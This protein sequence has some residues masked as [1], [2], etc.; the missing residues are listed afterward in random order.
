M[1]RS[2]TTTSPLAS[3]LL[4][5]GGL[6]L[7]VGIALGVQ[8]HSIPDPEYA[9]LPAVTCGTT[10][11]SSSDGPAK[12]LFAAQCAGTAPLRPLAWAL[13]IAGALA[14]IGGIAAVAARKTATNSD[15]RQA[16][17]D[18]RVREQAE[19]DAS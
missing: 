11:A 16:D 18:R 10:Y 13:T 7:I 17:Y 1:T 3:L 12:Y 15:A 5:I 19:L 2:R 9:N 14:V 6:A 8:S 4:V